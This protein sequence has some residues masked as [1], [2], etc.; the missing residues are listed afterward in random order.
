MALRPSDTYNLTT[1][2]GKLRLVLNDNDAMNAASGVKPDGS[3]YSDAELAVFIELAGSW[4]RAVS[5]TLRAL[6]NA[7]AKHATV[8]TSNDYREDLSK[9]SAQYSEAASQWDEHMNKLALLAAKS[10]TPSVSWADCF[11][12]QEAPR[13]FGMNQYGARI[14]DAV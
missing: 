14:T 6:A 9:I 11:G 7:Y 2:V 3:S 13:I 8:Q 1:D 5:V 10:E 12:Y 4:Q